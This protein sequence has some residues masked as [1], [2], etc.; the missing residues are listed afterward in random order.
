MS[1][2]RSG[3][4]VVNLGTLGGVNVNDPHFKEILRQFDAAVALKKPNHL[5]RKRT[6][7]SGS[8]GP[9]GSLVSSEVGVEQATQTSHH[10][11][12]RLLLTHHHRRRLL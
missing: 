6:E 2:N 4:T 7:G 8:S 11:R 10:P 9:T 12:H 3:K 1:S 5:K